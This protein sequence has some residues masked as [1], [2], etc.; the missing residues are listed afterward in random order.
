[1]EFSTE[2]S[3]QR[4]SGFQNY[5]LNADCI[6]CESSLMWNH[7]HRKKIN[8]DTICLRKGLIH[9]KVWRSLRAIPKTF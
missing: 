8:S 6:D 9:N 3:D 4:S 7:L 1:M 2:E 5:F